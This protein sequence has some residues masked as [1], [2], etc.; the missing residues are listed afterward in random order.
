MFPSTFPSHLPTVWRS[1]SKK[2]LDEVCEFSNYCDWFNIRTR[3]DKETPHCA[4]AFPLT[5]T[6][7]FICRSYAFTRPSSLWLFRTFTSTCVLFLTALYRTPNGPD[8]RSVVLESGSSFILSQCRIWVRFD[9]VLYW[10]SVANSIP[11]ALACCDCM[12]GCGRR[13]E[14]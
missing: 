9:A 8:F 2:R 4:R 3:K 10:Q 12:M 1:E 7:K 14:I 13:A 11:L 6:Y 5:P